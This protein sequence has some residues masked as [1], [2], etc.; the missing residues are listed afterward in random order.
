MKWYRTYLFAGSGSFEGRDEFE[1]D[2]D[3]SAMMMAELLCDACS[4]VCKS[5][6]LSQGVRR[7]DA[8]FR[9]AA[10][11]PSVGAEQITA[12]MQTSLMRSEEAMRD[13]QWAVARSKR[14]VE[15]IDRLLAD[16]R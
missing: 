6:E 10:P 11:F 16:R 5:F 9:K 14:L 7:V 2:D 8:S 1:A 12:M 15:R 4:D 3:R 13:S